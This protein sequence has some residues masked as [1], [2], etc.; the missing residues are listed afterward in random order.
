[1][2][3]RH[4]HGNIKWTVT[5]TVR[6]RSLKLCWG[7]WQTVESG[8]R[9]GQSG[10]PSGGGGGECK[11]NRAHGFVERQKEVLQRGGWKEQAVLCSYAPT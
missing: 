2:D 5:A 3:M 9:E 4:I 7:C 10:E 1:M 11:D 8:T 6:W